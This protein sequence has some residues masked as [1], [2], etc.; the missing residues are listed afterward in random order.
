MVKIITGP[1]GGQYYLRSGRKVYLK[2]PG[3]A[4]YESR[5]AAQP[6]AGW[7][8][9]FPRKGTERHLLMKK[10][11][12]RC[13][14]LPGSEGFPVCACRPRQGVKCTCSY[15]CAGITA[16]YGRARQHKYPKVASKALK[17][18]EKYCRK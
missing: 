12:N 14:L 8:K 5:R 10:C 16:A 7:G 18:R 15:D 11:G 6:A 2:R 9:R 3:I 1:R 17:L 13:F 4:S